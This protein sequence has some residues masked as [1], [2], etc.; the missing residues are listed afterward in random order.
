[1]QAIDR[2]IGQILL[3]GLRA[4][5]TLLV[6]LADHGQID[7]PA[8]HW[9]WLNDQPALLALLRV[10]PTGD[11]RAVILH[12]SPGCE[13]VAH[14]YLARHLAHCATV[15]PTGEAITLGLY[16]PEPLAS[17]VRERLGQL[18]VLPGE[19]WVIRYEYPG[20]E[21]KRWQVGTHGGLAAQEMLVPL[22]ACRLD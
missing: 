14:R 21:R 20:K 7:I 16:G 4:P 3:D 5:R 15:L 19:D 17:R 11:Q 10:P 13:A 18:L 22:L 1:M 9:V 2:A 6:I 12:A 8:A